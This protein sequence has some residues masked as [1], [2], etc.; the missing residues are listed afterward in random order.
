MYFSPLL[1]SL[2]LSLALRFFSFQEINFEN[3][4][5]TVKAVGAVAGGAEPDSGNHDLGT[6]KQKR[7][8]KKAGFNTIG[9]QFSTLR[10]NFALFDNKAE[11]GKPEITEETFVPPQ[12]PSSS[13]NPIPLQQIAE[14]LSPRGQSHS[15]FSTPSVEHPLQLHP[16]GNPNAHPP[17]PP[18]RKSTEPPPILNMLEKSNEKS[19]E[20]PE[21]PHHE[22]SQDYVNKRS[23][24]FRSERNLHDYVQNERNNHP[25]H[26]SAAATSEDTTS[27][28]E[29]TTNSP[30]ISV[31]SPLTNSNS[32]SNCA[33]E[34]PSLER[35]TSKRLPLL[36]A[37]DKR[38]STTPV[39][40]AGIEPLKSPKARKH[41]GR[42]FIRG[43]YFFFSLFF[44]SFF[45]LILE[46]QSS[47]QENWCLKNQLQR[48]R[49]L[50]N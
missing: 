1:I 45:V 20:N 10:K 35:S 2:I 15:H 34:R 19:F 39:P 48:F 13:F 38:S 37:R 36:S 44:F 21:N 27:R 11:G 6:L 47:R 42:L 40:P 8:S 16:G 29:N 5:I 25:E 50:P 31:S 22:E 4:F 7:S 3:L 49:H 18:K 33:T 43:L 24:R 41:I 26:K 28:Y 14:I 9:S 46:N 12:N 30:S 32:L 23:P 17:P